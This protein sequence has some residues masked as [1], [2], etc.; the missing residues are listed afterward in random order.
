MLPNLLHAKLV[1]NTFIIVTFQTITCKIVCLYL[2]PLL[3]HRIGNLA[4][5]AAL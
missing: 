4:Y 3:L 5:L 2:V 1:V